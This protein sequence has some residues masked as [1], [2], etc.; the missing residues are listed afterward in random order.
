MYIPFEQMP[1]HSR[2]WIFAAQRSFSQEEAS[3]ISAALVT[4]CNQWESHGGPLTA[5]FH[6]DRNRFV[7]LAVD[8]QHLGPG[9]CSIDKSV[10]AIR[11]LEGEL[12]HS[13]LER[14]KIAVEKSG[15]IQMISTREVKS[16]ISSGD[17]TPDSWI[18]DTTVPS[19]EK[20]LL[21][22]RV[23]AKDSWLGRHWLTEKASA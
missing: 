7:L 4:F 19:K 16:K 12:G 14:D 5:S 17:L 3:T 6:I 2:L 13:L 22:W 20:W 18:F 15:Q 8:D 23:L 21:A 11:A 9:G 1:N 10:H